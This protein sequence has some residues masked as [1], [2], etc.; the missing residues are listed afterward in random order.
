MKEAIAKH[1]YTGA[2]EGSIS[3][4]FTDGG[5]TL[6]ISPKAL[7]GNRWDAGVLLEQ[8]TGPIPR[9]P[10]LPISR[11]AEFRGLPAVSIWLKIRAVGVTAHPFL[12]RTLTATMPEVRTAAVEIVTQMAE[13][14]LFGDGTVS[15]I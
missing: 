4:E 8:G 11:W 13:K 10:W 6:T 2:L 9:A 12:E 3:G 14:A 5:Y 1:R 7:R 15:S